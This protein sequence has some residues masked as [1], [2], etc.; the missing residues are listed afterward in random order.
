MEIKNK[1]TV[2]RGKGEG[3]WGGRRGRVKSRNMYIKD[4]WIRTTLGGGQVECGRGVVGRARESNGGKM[5]TTEIE[6]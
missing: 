3:K 4:S 5:G 1:L 2:T 6:Q